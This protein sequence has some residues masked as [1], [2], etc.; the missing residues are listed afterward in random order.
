MQYN[1]ENKVCA[2]F[3]HPTA[4]SL[5]TAD[6]GPGRFP[7]ARDLLY[8]CG[9]QS[10]AT[11]FSELKIHIDKWGLHHRPVDSNGVA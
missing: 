10:F 7:D 1:T 5:L 2:K 8:G 11:I 9:A 4:W 3:V 6:A